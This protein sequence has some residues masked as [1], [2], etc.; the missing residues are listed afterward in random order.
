MLGQVELG[1]SA[2][3]INVLWKIV[4]ALDVPFAALVT[5]EATSSVSLVKAKAS[6]SLVSF[7]GSFRSR[8]LFPFD[9]NRSVEFYELRITPGGREDAEPHAQGTTENLVVAA[10]ELRLEVNGETHALTQGD[11]IF[12]VA[13]RPHAYVNTGLTEATLYLVMTYTRQKS[14]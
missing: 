5:N 10:G 8:A 12:F 9:A 11:A 13:D 14:T 4:A 6:K 7:D 2:P 1:Q 3:T